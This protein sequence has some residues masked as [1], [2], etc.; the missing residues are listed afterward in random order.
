[1]LTGLWITLG[2]LFVWA[3]VVYFLVNNV[4]RKMGRYLEC[5][6]PNFMNKCKAG[7]RYDFANVNYNKMIFV[8]TFILPLRLVLLIIS[9]IL[10]TLLVLILKLLYC[11]K[12]MLM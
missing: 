7:S 10:T 8:G 6:P 4:V 12:M 9:V 3:L 2:C 5:P 1:M 11:G